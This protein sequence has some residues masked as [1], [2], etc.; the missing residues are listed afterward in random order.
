V[1]RIGNPATFFLSRRERG[2]GEHSPD[3]ASLAFTLAACAQCPAPPPL[4]E[5]LSRLAD[6]RERA[7]EARRMILCRQNTLARL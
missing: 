6:S 3:A 7:A 1:T 2:A 5:I 4:R